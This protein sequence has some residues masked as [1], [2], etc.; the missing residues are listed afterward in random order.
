MKTWKRTGMGLALVAALAGCAGPNANEQTGLIVG[1]IVGGVVGSHIGRGSGQDVATFV[2][3]VTGA[4]IGGNIGRS[5]DESDRIRTTLVLQNVRTGVPARWTNPRTSISYTV[6]PTR[7]YDTPTGL[8]REYTV[9]ALIGGQPQKV[10]GTACLQ[11]DGSWRV[12]N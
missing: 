8:C 1:A 9:D 2:G 4:V 11:P 10:W 3:A 7:S 5:M 6:V 12:V